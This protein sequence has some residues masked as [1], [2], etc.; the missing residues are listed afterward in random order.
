LLQLAGPPDVQPT[1]LLSVSVAALLGQT[2][3]PAGYGKALALTLQRLD[4]PPHCGDL[5]G[6]QPL[7]QHRLSPIQ[8]IFS[9]FAWL[10]KCR[11]GQLHSI[12][13]RDVRCH[14]LHSG[15]APE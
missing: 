1:V 2:R 7:I 11:S 8:A 6:S 4:R 15:G 12:N 14:G 10:R 13:G 5:L 9:Q 3:S